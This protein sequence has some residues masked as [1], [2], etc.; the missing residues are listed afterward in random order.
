DT[1]RWEATLAWGRNRNRPGHTLDAFMAEATAALGER[2]VVFARAER[3]EKD[4]LFVEPDPRAGQAF[5]V[6]EMTA[7]Y[8]FE[9]WR[10]EHVS[11]G[12]GLAG[13]L[14][15]VPRELR[16]AYGATPASLLVF[17]HGAIR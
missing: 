17:V 8:R 9:F 12:I 16:D 7:G 6:G 5:N 1:G 3:V 14:A 15:Y 13:T 2:H 4:E 10:Q 11:T